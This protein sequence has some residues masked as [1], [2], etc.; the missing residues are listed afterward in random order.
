VSEPTFTRER[1]SRRR[2]GGVSL[3]ELLV[4]MALIGLVATVLTS[5]IIVILRTAPSTELRTDDARSTRGL[6]TW[7]S[8]DVTSTPPFEPV[9]D[10]GGFSM[11][12]SANTCGAPAGG[13]TLIELTWV[14]LNRTFAATYR[15]ETANSGDAA[16]RRYACS[17]TDSSGWS[18]P[19]RT[20][21]TSG[22]DPSNPGVVGL[23]KD[24]GRVEIVR[25]RL[26]GRSGDDILLDVSPRNPSEFFP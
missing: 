11:S 17:R 4:V 15:T 3:V 1:T 16:I 20:N 18:A 7:L 10:R 2:D 13:V 19:S 24:N 12:P 25:V 21:L 6:A 14:Q 9:T 26:T 8:H 23:V 5:A 22:L